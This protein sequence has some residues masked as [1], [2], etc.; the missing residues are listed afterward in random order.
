MKNNH[1]G[2]YFRDA[3]PQ[4]KNT[5]DR[6]KENSRQDSVHGAI[7]KDATIAFVN[8]SNSQNHLAGV[9]CNVILAKSSN[10]LLRL[11]KHSD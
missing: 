11:K 3:K 4:G 10:R 2:L 5:N 9:V 1:V 6:S 8:K 7:L